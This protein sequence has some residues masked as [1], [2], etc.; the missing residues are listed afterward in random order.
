M[1]EILSETTSPRLGAV[2]K[3]P[4]AS[5]VAR[6]PILT[7]N[8]QERGD[9]VVFERQH[10]EMQLLPRDEGIEHALV[11][12]LILAEQ[13]CLGMRLTICAKI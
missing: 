11:A 6:C 13:L 8:P 10:I 2:N 1:S 9:R 3:M 12:V 7:S 4:H 5:S